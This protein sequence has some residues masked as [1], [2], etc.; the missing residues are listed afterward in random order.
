MKRSAVCQKMAMRIDESRINK[1]AR[2]V[3]VFIS[4][5]FVHDFTLGTH[6][7]DGAVF[8]GHSL[9]NGEFIVYGVYDC[10]MYDQVGM[11]AL[12]SAGVQY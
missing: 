3:D 12:K 1:L 10:V 9:C 2:T 5:V 7:D 8:Y 4:G 11:F 6:S